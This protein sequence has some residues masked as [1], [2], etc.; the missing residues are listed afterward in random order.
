[1][2]FKENTVEG[3]HLQELGVNGNGSCRIGYKGV[4]WIK[5]ANDEVQMCEYFNRVYSH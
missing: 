4:N 3:G 2:L 5:V 1:M